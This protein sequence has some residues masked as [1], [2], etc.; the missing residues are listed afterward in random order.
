[1]FG[2]YY[3]QSR[4]LRWFWRLVILGF[5]LAP[6]SISRWPEA[7]ESIAKSSSVVLL[8]MEMFSIACMVGGTNWGRYIMSLAVF[9]LGPLWLL[10][11]FTS[12]RRLNKKTQVGWFFSTRQVKVFRFYQIHRASVFSFSI[13]SRTWF[14]TCPL[15]PSPP[16][17]PSRTPSRPP[18]G[19]PYLTSLATKSSIPHEL[20]V[21]SVAFPTQRAV[22]PRNLLRT[23]Y[24]S[25]GSMI[26]APPPT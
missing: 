3:T 6:R 19:G 7:F 26:V 4:I 23:L 15:S 8:D 14:L 21:P 2:A 16:L 5:P 12:S 1:M 22:S 9:P 20:C 10:V 25:C 18:L 24:F 11:C 17:A 13:V